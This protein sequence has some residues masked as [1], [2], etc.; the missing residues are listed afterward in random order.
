MSMLRSTPK[1][2]TVEE[3]AGLMVVGGRAPWPCA[4]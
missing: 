1:I 2:F 3:S 4:N